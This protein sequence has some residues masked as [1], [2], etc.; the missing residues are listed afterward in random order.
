MLRT[1]PSRIRLGQWQFS[2]KS[3]LIVLTMASIPCGVYAWR[4]AREDRLAAMVEDFNRAIDEQ[5]WFDAQ[6]IAHRFLDECPNSPV[7]IHMVQK[8][9]LLVSLV[10]GVDYGLVGS[11]CP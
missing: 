2:L 3:L 8:S 11:G 7:G 10:H 6:V 1:V 4:Q 9:R 5:R